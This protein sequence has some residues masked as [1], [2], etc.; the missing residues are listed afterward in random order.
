MKC[1]GVCADAY[2]LIIIFASYY[3]APW[4]WPCIIIIIIIL[5]MIRERHVILKATLHSRL[6]VYCS[7]LHNY[8]VLPSIIIITIFLRELIIIAIVI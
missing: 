1:M 7:E 4:P 5:R 8:A 3:Y 6:A 2:N